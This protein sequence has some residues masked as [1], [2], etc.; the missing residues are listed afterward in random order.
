MFSLILNKL[1][2]IKY[3]ATKLLMILLGLNMLVSCAEPLE[4]SDTSASGEASDPQSDENIIDITQ[5]IKT[6]PKAKFELDLTTESTYKSAKKIKENS[7]KIK[8]EPP[9]AEP[10]IKD[11]GVETQ[12]YPEVPAVKDQHSEKIPSSSESTPSTDE[13][14]DPN[15]IL[16]ASN[17]KPFI[18]ILCFIEPKIQKSALTLKLAKDQYHLVKGNW[19]IGSHFF[20]QDIDLIEING[21]TRFYLVDIKS[22]KSIIES[23]NKLISNKYG[24]FAN[25]FDFIKLQE[26]RAISANPSMFSSKTGWP[27]AVFDKKNKQISRLLRVK[28]AE[29]LTKH[30]R[31]IL[32]QHLKKYYELKTNFNFAAVVPGI[33]YRS[34]YLADKGIKAV[35]NFFSKSRA[36]KSIAS[37]HVI[38][39]KKNKDNSENYNL[40]ELKNAPIFGY[41]FL[42]SYHFD[43]KKTVYL[44]GKSPSTV[45]PDSKHR[46][47]IYREKTIDHFLPDIEVKKLL[48][49]D[50]SRES[51]RKLVGNIDDFFNTMEN[52][53]NAVAPTLSLQRRSTQNRHASFS[54]RVFK[55]LK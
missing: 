40:N 29:S 46:G 10:L 37:I 26:V 38:G 39:W 44:D 24:L 52:L 15:L 21:R 19:F 30:Q 27:V 20:E 3:S 28:S 32:S 2:N 25:N 12:N 34:S 55:P 51:G 14:F 22:Q 8:N 9:L 23:C 11:P 42:H 48:K 36:P 31:S 6:E 49:I 5:L 43:P 41:D 35:Y 33:I 1:N 53:I 47:D 17:K 45:P 18:N 54:I 13:T 16:E 50:E 7:R 4:N